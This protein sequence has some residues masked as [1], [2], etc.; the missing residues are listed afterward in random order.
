MVTEVNKFLDVPM[1]LIEIQIETDIYIYVN[2]IHSQPYIR[3]RVILTIVR[4]AFRIFQH[5]ALNEF[6]LRKIFL[7]FI[8]MI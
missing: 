3:P 1:S 4:K 5:Y 6:V 2:P 7:K 8:V